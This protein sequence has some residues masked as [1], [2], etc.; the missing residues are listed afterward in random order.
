M[1]RSK[2]TSGESLRAITERLAS[3]ISSVRRGG[4]PSPPQ[5]SSKGSVC[6]VA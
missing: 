6:V 2:G 4:A 3:R 1:E 5:P